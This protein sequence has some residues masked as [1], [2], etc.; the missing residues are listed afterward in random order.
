MDELCREETCIFDAAVPEAEQIDH[1]K[2]SKTKRDLG[3]REQMAIVRT[4]AAVRVSQPRSLAVRRAGGG[5]Y[6]SID[7]TACMHE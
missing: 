4:F 1:S 3:L 2:T 6:S 7:S 5:V